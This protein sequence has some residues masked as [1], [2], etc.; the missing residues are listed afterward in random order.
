MFWKV[1][2]RLN[3]MQV[4][5]KHTYIH[6]FDYVCIKKGSLAEIQTATDWNLISHSLTTCLLLFHIVI[7]LI[8]LLAHSFNA[9]LPTKVLQCCSI[10][11]KAMGSKQQISPGD[12]MVSLMCHCQQRYHHAVKASQKKQW[13]G[14]NRLNTL[15]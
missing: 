12:Y 3:F 6:T 2:H 4:G 10:T 9:S 8:I 11:E 5:I 1:W 7:I 14:A 13:V 15:W